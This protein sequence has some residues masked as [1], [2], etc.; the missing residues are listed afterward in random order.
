MSRRLYLFATALGAFLLQTSCQ[1]RTTTAEPGAAVFT[2]EPQSSIDEKTEAEFTSDGSDLGELKKLVE[3][4]IPDP[5]KEQIGLEDETVD[6]ADSEVVD[7][8]TAGDS[9]QEAVV[10][11]DAKPKETQNAAP[12]P[13]APENRRVWFA[14]NGRS[15]IY[16]TPDKASQQQRK[17]EAG[18]RVVG[19]L[20]G[21]WIKVSASEWVH[22]QD[23][24][25]KPPRTSVAKKASKWK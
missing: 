24:G 3:Q 21:D 14:K 2:T 13:A 23:V 18:E 8:T 6:R 10:K 20:L 1:S 17:M 11:A 25:D 7:P 9:E 4:D 15:V 22:T 5:N 19:E 12:A 16:A